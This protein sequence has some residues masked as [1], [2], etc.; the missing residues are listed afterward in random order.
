MNQTIEEFIEAFKVM[1]VKRYN[2]SVTN[3]AVFDG[4]KLKEAH[5]KSLSKEEAYYS[6][7]NMSQDLSSLGL[8]KGE[9]DGD[10]KAGQ[11]A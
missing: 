2:W 11:E 4:E 10:G 1:L 6:V 5:E 3:A 9:T 7:F 8:Q